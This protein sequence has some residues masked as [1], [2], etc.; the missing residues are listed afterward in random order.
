MATHEWAYD[1]EGRL[2]RARDAIDGETYYLED[3]T[4]VH[5]R[6]PTPPSRKPV[7]HFAKFPC[8]YRRGHTA[9][10]GDAAPELELDTDVLLRSVLRAPAGHLA[11]GG[12]RGPGGPGEREGGHA[13]GGGVPAVTTCESLSALH[14]MALYRFRPEDPRSHS[15]AI[16]YGSW[17]PA[18]L[19]NFTA[20]RLI[21]E[22]RP[23]HIDYAGRSIRFLRKW[24]QADGS[25]VWLFF[26]L[27]FDDKDMFFEIQKRLKFKKEETPRGTMRWV[28]GV[29]DVLLAGDWQAVEGK[30]AGFEAKCINKKQVYVEP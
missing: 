18:H 2:I 9:R 25:E 27:H 20:G 19:I 23:K 24:L 21:I 13:V 28:P 29:G 5:V 11:G 6:K 1:R 26:T 10:T 14:K 12:G 8:D 16:I 4:P 3:K 22:A 17:T 15:D 7:P 30:Y